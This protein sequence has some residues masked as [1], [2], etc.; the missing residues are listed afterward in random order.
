MT[1]AFVL[2]I[3]P[4][5][6]QRG[7]FLSPWLVP[8]IVKHSAQDIQLTPELDNACH[9]LNFG[10]PSFHNAAATFGN[11]EMVLLFVLRSVLLVKHDGFCQ[12]LG[13]SIDELYLLYDFS[14]LHWYLPPI[15]PWS[16]RRN[17]QSDQ[18]TTKALLPVRRVLYRFVCTANQHLLCSLRSDSGMI[19]ILPLPPFH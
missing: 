2:L 4:D 14:L 6:Q 7:Q 13:K 18:A 9:Y 15:L 16:H 17:S 11:A 3:W 8:P 19:F 12:L 5:P 10:S 1:S